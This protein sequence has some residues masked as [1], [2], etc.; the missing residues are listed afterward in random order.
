MA[1][2][3]GKHCLETVGRESMQ[4]IIHIILQSKILNMIENLSDF[5]GSFSFSFPKVLPTL[6]SKEMTNIRRYSIQ[7]HHLN[8]YRPLRVHFQRFSRCSL[9]YFT[10]LLNYCLFLLEGYTFCCSTAIPLSVRVFTAPKWHSARVAMK[11]VQRVMWRL[12]V[13]LVRQKSSR[14]PS[15]LMAQWW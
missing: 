5:C 1:R 4:I 2:Q 10:N 11:W 12:I 9:S 15:L 8:S 6:R 3:G 7:I 13:F 14:W